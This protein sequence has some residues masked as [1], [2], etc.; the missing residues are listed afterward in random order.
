MSNE[1]S[2]YT[3]EAARDYWQ[4][5]CKRIEDR[6]NE[7]EKEREELREFLTEVDLLQEIGTYTKMGEALDVVIGKH[8]KLIEKLKNERKGV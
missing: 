3:P 8:A 4:N 1:I 5:R 6:V 2:E 7:L